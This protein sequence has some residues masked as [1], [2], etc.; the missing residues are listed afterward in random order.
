MR[1]FRIGDSVQA[2]WDANLT[3]EIIDM[4]HKKTSNMLTATGPTDFESLRFKIKIRGTEKIVEVKSSD[5]F[6][7][8]Y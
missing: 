1:R 6:H 8:E 5:V 3:G 2:F 7:L 4:Y